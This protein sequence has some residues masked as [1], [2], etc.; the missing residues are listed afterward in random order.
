MNIRERVLEELFDI[1]VEEKGVCE[2]MDRAYN[3]WYQFCCENT[4]DDQV[5]NYLNLSTEMQ[6][7][8]FLAGARMAFDLIGGR[9]DD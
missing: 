9:K 6:R 1:A 5:D 4:P 8:A 2:D 7:E 3:E